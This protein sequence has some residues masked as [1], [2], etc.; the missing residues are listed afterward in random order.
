[1]DNV[2][3]SEVGLG[4]KALVLSIENPELELALM[5]LGLMSGDEVTVSDQAPLGGP[6]ALRIPGGK[7]AIRRSDARKI[8]V[9]QI[10]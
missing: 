5:R 2:K 4:Q 10:A 9:R 3:L 8:K 6:I 1:M 7:V